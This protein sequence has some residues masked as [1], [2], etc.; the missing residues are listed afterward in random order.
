VLNQASRFHINDLD[1]EEGI[2]KWVNYLS[3]AADFHIEEST[4]DAAF[5]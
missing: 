1:N 2:D 4:L 3:E 5:S